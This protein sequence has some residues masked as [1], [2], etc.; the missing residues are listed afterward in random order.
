MKVLV[1]GAG[2]YGCHACM[3]LENLGI[4]YKICDTANEFFTGSSS[5]NQ[6]RLHLG[7][8]YPRS[9]KTRNE[10]QTGFDK[11]MEVYGQFTT[12]IPNN[13]YCID[14]KSLMDCKSYTS[15]Y[16]YEKIPFED[17]TMMDV[18]F[19][20]DDSSIDGIIRVD[21]RFIDFRKAACHFREKL[22]QHMIKGYSKEM[23]N[24]DKLT[25]NNESFDMIIDCTYSTVNKNMFYETCISLIY[26]CKDPS[27]FAITVVDGPFWSLYPYDSEG[28][29]YTLTDVE[30]TPSGR[31]DSRSQIE[32]K[33]HKYI[34]DFH[35]HFTYKGY[36]LSNK[37]KPGD[38]CSDDRS[39]VWS[40]KANVIKFSGGKLTGIFA[41]ED[42]LYEELP[43]PQ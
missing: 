36:F 17:K 13:Y 10:C 37:A 9:F 31:E 4:Q 43:L 32:A 14:K 41:M 27:M 38:V 28:R 19:S 24:I 30:H 35:K 2:W 25:Y 23:L 3:V 21:E 20:V 8:H 40:R 29:L 15:I 22:S 16:K 6:N 5:K 11:F 34:P 26:E 39:L 1:L 18:P 42:I 7:F 33:V 12:E